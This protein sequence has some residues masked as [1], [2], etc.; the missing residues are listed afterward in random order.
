MAWLNQPRTRSIDTEDRASILILPLIL[1]M[2]FAYVAGIWHQVRNIYFAVVLLPI[3]VP[4]IFAAMFLY[5]SSTATKIIGA[6]ICVMGNN[7]P[8]RLCTASSA[9]LVSH[10]GIDAICV[11]PGKAD[12]FQHV[13]SCD[14][15]VIRA[16]L[17]RLRPRS[18]PTCARR[19]PCGK[20]PSHTCRRTSRRCG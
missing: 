18:G 14:G 20:A 1:N 13:K 11:F 2:A 3:V 10:H 7:S 8:R 12:G 9:G 15:S 4:V 16:A 6:A 5:G 17:G 19:Y